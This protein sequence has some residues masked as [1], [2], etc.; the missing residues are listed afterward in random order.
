[1][2]LGGC[3]S[4]VRS[5]PAPAARPPGPP[6]PRPSPPP[7]AP[8]PPQSTAGVDAAKAGRLPAALTRRYDVYFVPEE[9]IPASEGG[10]PGGKGGGL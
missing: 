5:G 7:P 9:H 4:P 8:P 3:S 1:V 10:R 2:P 6:S